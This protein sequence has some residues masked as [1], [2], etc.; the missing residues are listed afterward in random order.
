MLR[1]MPAMLR[2]LA[3]FAGVLVL[4]RVGLGLGLSLMAGAVAVDLWAGRGVAAVAGDLGHALSRPEMW[5]LLA[6][7]ALILE[8]GRFMAAN[9]NA[10]VVVA[11]ARRLGGRYGRAASVMILPAVIGLI[12]MPGGALFSAPLVANT[13]PG[14][15]WPAAWKSAVNYW[16]RHVWEFWWPLYPVV[17]LTLSIFRLETWQFVAAM[18][19]FSIVAI[20][21]GGLFLVRPHL[22]TLVEPRPVEE[23]LP[24]GA[25]RLAL[26]LGLILGSAL[27]LPPL[28]ALGFPAWTASVRKLA[29]MLVGLVA[30]V[31]LI[32]SD[33]RHDPDAR[34]FRGLLRRE[35]LNILLA[36][37]GVLIFQILLERSGLI[38]AAAAELLGSG[39]PPV[40]VVAVLPFVAGLVTGIG[41]GYA[42]TSFPLVVGLL[43]QDGSGLSVLATLVLAFGCG[44]AGMMLSPVHLCLVLTRDYFRAPF[45]PIYRQI[46]PC[47]LAILAAAVG[48]HAL[49]A[50]R[51]W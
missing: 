21:A 27:V 35:S 17:I 47:V 9:H 25:W 42:G 16:F 24:P 19:P 2:I 30:A 38:P 22:G 36:L 6:V 14:E 50:A 39:I 4:D 20:G 32:R 7:I 44:Y 13:V 43:Q 5:L 23:E 51:G 12:P 34:P 28:L 31:G 41:I 10:A 45:A 40:T 3:V 46:L 15:S 29:A 26:P 11:A 49:F 37:A 18:C 1:T 8:V 33:E 48:L